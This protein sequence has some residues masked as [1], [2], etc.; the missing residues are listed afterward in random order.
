M[1]SSW[2]RPEAKCSDFLVPFILYHNDPKE[3]PE[4]V[5][6]YFK[7]AISKDELTLPSLLAVFYADPRLRDNPDKFHEIWQDF[8]TTLWHQRPIWRE[9]RRKEMRAVQAERERRMEAGK[10]VRNGKERRKKGEAAEIQS[11]AGGAYFPARF[12]GR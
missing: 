9:E 12:R 1:S 4:P 2:Y 11:L 8:I 3:L 6:E 7:Q 10:Y 5:H